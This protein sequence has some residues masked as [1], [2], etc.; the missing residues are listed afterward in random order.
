MGRK[1]NTF[2]FVGKPYAD[3][4]SGGRK[5]GQVWDGGGTCPIWVGEITGSECFSTQSPSK[6]TKKAGRENYKLA[7]RAGGLRERRQS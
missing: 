3:T 5:G 7:A 6:R 4:G 1:G 2:F